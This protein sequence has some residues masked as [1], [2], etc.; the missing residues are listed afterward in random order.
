MSSLGEALRAAGMRV[1]IAPVG[2]RCLEQIHSRPPDVV[3]VEFGEPETAVLLRELL[4][5]ATRP[6]IMFVVDALGDNADA[7]RLCLA[8]DHVRP[9]CD[10]GELVLRLEVLVARRRTSTG[11]ARFEAGRVQ[12]DRDARQVLV[13]GRPVSLSATE[14][15]LLLLLVRNAGRVVTKSA[16][17]DHVWRYEFQG[18]SNIVESYIYGLRRKLSDED[19]SLIRTIRGIGYLF[20]DERPS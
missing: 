11:G 4:G 16:I 3:L 7:D 17:L 13:G 10:P 14:F 15:E 2:M 18:E 9:D 19:R 6:G 12:I 20:A 5:M 8:D 1:E